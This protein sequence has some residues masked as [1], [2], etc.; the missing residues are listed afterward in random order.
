MHP[1]IARVLLHELRPPARG[2]VVDPF[3]GSGTVLVEAMIAGLRGVGGDSSPL[4]SR[5]ARVKTERRGPRE[6]ERFVVAAE[7]V[8]AASSARVRGRVRVWASLPAAEAAWYAPHVLKELA[9][10]LEEIRR[11]EADADRRALE[12]VFSAIVVK[13]AEQVSST[14]PDRVH[15]R[16]R[17]GLPTEFFVRKAR[18]LARRWADLDAAI[19]DRRSPAPIVHEID[20]RRLAHTLGRTFRADLVLGSPPYGGT[21]DYVEHHAR[22]AAWLGWSSTRLRESEIGARRSARE[23][24]A[25]ARWDEQMAEVLTGVATLLRPG[26]PCVWVM[27][28]ARWSGADVPADEQLAR[29]CEGTDLEFVAAE[30]ELRPDRHGGRERRE[31]IVALVRR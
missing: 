2:T 23:P 22:S 31:H 12:M 26:A 30:S 3:C 25:I 29:L 8:A 15:K 9:G 1:A 13:F 21:Y 6:R 20:V 24:D 5:L 27:G 10:L 11:V 19:R 28:D 17:K 14:R 4:A 16:I 7:R 18:E